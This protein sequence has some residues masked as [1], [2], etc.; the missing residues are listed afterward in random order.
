MEK[1][2]IKTM[3]ELLEIK[4]DG[5]YYLS[6][7]IDCKGDPP[8]DRLI[9]DFRGTID[10]QNHRIKNLIIAPEII[11][12]GQPVALIHTAQNAVIMNLKIENMSIQIKKNGYEPKV[13]AF[14]GLFEKGIIDNVQVD[15]AGI[16]ED[17]PLIG[18]SGQSTY[19]KVAYSNH[20]KNTLC[21]YTSD[22]N[23]EE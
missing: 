10:G 16:N 6:S 11:S 9:G 20:Y 5:N 12:D 15:L 13:S 21:G 1:T 18:E 17:V 8:I 7:D 23:V 3:E 4:R 2:E 19:R 22:D 14:F